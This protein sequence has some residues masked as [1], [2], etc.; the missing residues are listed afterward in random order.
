MKKKAI[1]IIAGV[2]VVAIAIGLISMLAINNQENE[3]ST[4]EVVLEKNVSVITSKTTENEQPYKVDEN[5]LYYKNNPDL[6]KDDVVVSGITEAAPTGFMRKIV[7]IEKL[8]GEYVVETIPANFNEVFKA[9]NFEDSIDLNETTASSEIK[10]QSKLLSPTV[11]PLSYDSESAVFIKINEKTIDE[12]GIYA[13]VSGSLDLKI[14]PK[15]QVADDN[16]IFDLLWENG[17]ESCIYFFNTEDING[18]IEKELRKYKFMPR[19]FYIGA[20]PVVLTNEVS[21][22]LKVDGE[23]TGEISADLKLNDVISQGFQYVSNEKAYYQNDSAE[24]IENNV[25]LVVHGPVDSDATIG[26]FVKSATTLYDGIS[27]E[28]Y[29]GL[30]ADITGDI[31]IDDTLKSTNGI[32]YGVLETLVSADNVVEFIPGEPLC[33]DLSEVPITFDREDEFLWED[34]KAFNGP[35]APGEAWIASHFYKALDFYEHS[36]YGRTYRVSE[37]EQ[38][39]PPFED[40]IM[41]NGEWLAPYPHNDFPTYEDFVAQCGEYFDAEMTEAIRH[42]IAGEDYKGA[43]YSRFHWG[44]GDWRLSDYNLSV[45]EIQLDEYTYYYEVY[46]SFENIGGEQVNVEMSCNYK[47]GKWLFDRC[48]FYGEDTFQ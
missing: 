34:K 45:K 20:V 30:K 14:H 22:Y 29:S 44:I 28:N 13:R 24:A 47:N 42:S 37:Q 17:I 32:R 6:K 46:G 19:E 16:V 7:S 35:V 23:I 41:F 3:L 48:A 25:D 9:V 10:T 11:M 36:L 18:T 33:T 40:A 39:T 21:A 1:A 27:V 8:N 26:V 5:H 2:V 43:F 4:E 15:L 31:R 38:P 12:D